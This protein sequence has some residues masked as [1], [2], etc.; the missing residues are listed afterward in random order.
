M[1]RIHML[2]EGARVLLYN[3]T[4]LLLE[5]VTGEYSQFHIETDHEH[6]VHLISTTPV[7]RTKGGYRIGTY[8]GWKKEGRRD[9]PDY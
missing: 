1:A 4:A 8:D 9:L 2:K 3:G 6:K 7:F 5:E